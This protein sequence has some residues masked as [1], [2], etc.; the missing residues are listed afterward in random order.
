M[1]IFTAVVVFLFLFSG[2][3]VAGPHDC[4]GAVAARMAQFKV[5]PDQIVLV[6][7]DKDDLVDSCVS[8]RIQQ[9]VENASTANRGVWFG[10][11]VRKGLESRPTTGADDDCLHGQ[12]V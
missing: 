1:R 7:T 9:P 5:S 3:A 10:G 6:S 8:Q 4:A 2:L 12:R 11:I